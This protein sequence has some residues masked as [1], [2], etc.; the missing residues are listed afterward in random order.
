M[1]DELRRR[2]S[3]RARSVQRREAMVSRRHGIW[4]AALA[5]AAGAAARPGTEQ[6]FRPLAVEPDGHRDVFALS[7]NLLLGQTGL[8]SFGHAVYFGLGGFAAIHLMR[9]I[10]AGLPIPM[11]LVPL[12]GAA[13]GLVFGMLFGSVTTRRAGVVFALISLGVGELVFAASRMLPGLFRRR[14]GHHRQP[15]AGP[16]VFGLNFASQLQVYYLIA[17]WAFV[18]AALMYAFTRTPVGRMCNAVR[19]NPERAAF[20]GYSTQRVRFIVFS[21]AAMFAGLAG[22]LHAINYEIVAAD[23]VGAAR[24]GSVLLM[25]YIGGEAYFVGAILGA[26]TITWLQVSLSDYTT[27]WQLYL[28]L[29]FMA[30]VLFAPGGLAGLIMMH[31]PIV[32]TRAFRGVL[33]S[34]GVAL[35]PALV[36]L[37]GAVALLE[38]NYRLSTQPEAG[39]RMKLFG[40]GDRCGDAVAV[41]RRRRCSLVGGFFAFRTT[42]PVVAAAWQRASD[43]AGRYA[44]HA[45]DFAMTAAMRRA[46]CALELRGRA[47]EFR[48]DADHPRRLARRAARASAT[49]S[50]A[51]TAPASRRCST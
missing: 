20:V 45:R 37:V 51:R 32:R 27:A 49:R 6:Q 12:V 33:R 40:I 15:R 7:Y 23:A 9:A 26:I 4:L 17:F 48:R 42:W 44:D 38:I 39:S 34:Y 3:D 41:A 25:V 46:E 22:G 19:D 35:L 30:I 47:Q 16:H 18:A 8:L 10:N 21:V 13:A 2:V 5:L 1:S 14:G 24:S 36:M 31:A 28:G 50:S 43:E 29:F 11:P